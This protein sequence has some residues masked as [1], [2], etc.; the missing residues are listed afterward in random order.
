MTMTPEEKREA[1]ASLFEAL[2]QTCDD[3]GCPA[4]NHQVDCGLEGLHQPLQ[5]LAN[6]ATACV[7]AEAR[8]GLFTTLDEEP[9]E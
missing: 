3:H 6:A 4:H 7:E 8:S 9:S 5:S 2:Q 1:A